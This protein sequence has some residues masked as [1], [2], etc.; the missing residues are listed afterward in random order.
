VSGFVY[1]MT[2]AEIV[3]QENV[4]AGTDCGLGV[5]RPPANAWDRCARPARRR[6]AIASKKLWSWIQKCLCGMNKTKGRTSRIKS[7]TLD[8]SDVKDDCH[9]LNVS[10]AGA[11]GILN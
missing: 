5:P 6:V 7:L 8:F 3:G 11:E 1:L 10:R 4:I 2:F 9:L